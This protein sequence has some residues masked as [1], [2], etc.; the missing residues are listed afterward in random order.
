MQL[1]FAFGQFNHNV[2]L[3]KNQ[4]FFSLNCLPDRLG[5]NSQTSKYIIKKEVAYV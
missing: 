5:K 1:C 2:K 3:E 4:K